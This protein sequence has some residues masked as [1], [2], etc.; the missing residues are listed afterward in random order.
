MLVKLCFWYCLKRDLELL[1]SV[2]N[3]LRLYGDWFDLIE[4]TSI[5]GI[6]VDN[7]LL[8]GIFSFNWFNLFYWTFSR[9]LLFDFLFRFEFFLKFLCRRFLHFFFTLLLLW[10]IFSSSLLLFLSSLDFLWVFW[11]WIIIMSFLFLLVLLQLYF[12]FRIYF[13]T[14]YFSLLFALVLR[15]F[16]LG[17]LCF[18]WLLFDLDN[19]DLKSFFFFMCFVN[20]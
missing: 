9:P 18:L 6:I 13:I 7:S 4:F 12:I 8:L 1:S 16:F 20:I 15:L 11:L 10:F 19:L 17:F 2:W 3:L 14:A 5:L